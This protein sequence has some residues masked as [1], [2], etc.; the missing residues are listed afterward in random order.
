MYLS[1]RIV[2]NFNS[3][4]LNGLVVVKFVVPTTP[5]FHHRNCDVFA[6]TLSHASGPLIVRWTIYLGTCNRYHGINI[7]F[8]LLWSNDSVKTGKFRFSWSNIVHKFNSNQYQ[9]RLFWNWG[10]TRDSLWKKLVWKNKPSSL[11]IVCITARG[12]L[13]YLVERLFTFSRWF[14]WLKSNSA[15]FVL[16]K[17]RY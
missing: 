1:S 5:E 13:H 15:C 10:C 4:Q 8:P 2:I 6:L 17:L 16:N 11:W 9:V 12:S 7:R 3:K 14:S